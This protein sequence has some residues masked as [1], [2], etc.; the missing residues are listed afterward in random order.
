MKTTYEKAVEL[1][2]RGHSAL[3]VAQ[4]L[5][6]EHADTISDAE[7]FVNEQKQNAAS[8]AV[9]MFRDGA[10]HRDV[11]IALRGLGLPPY[12]ADELSL[13]AMGVVRREQAEAAE[14]ASD[15]PSKTS[16]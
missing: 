14:E 3:F 6:A 7:Q 15:V 1:F 10:P 9:A 12:D 2:W 4:Q 11:I 5:G 13:R 16:G 8:T